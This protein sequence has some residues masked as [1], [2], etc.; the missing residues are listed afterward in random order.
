MTGSGRKTIARRMFRRALPAIV[1]VH[2]PLAPIARLTTAGLQSPPCSVVPATIIGSAGGDWI[3]GT[4]GYDVIVGGGGNDV[5]QGQGAD[6]AICGEA[7]N[8]MISSGFG[9]DAI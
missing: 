6:D 4:S 9:N 1:L 8:D 2:T 7:G 5:I 3:S